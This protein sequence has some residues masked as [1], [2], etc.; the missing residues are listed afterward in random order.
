MTAIC[1]PVEN[2]KEGHRTD[3]GVQ[4]LNLAATFEPP[5]EQGSRGR[6]IKRLPLL[7]R[8]VIKGGIELTHCMSVAVCSVCGACVHRSI[9]RCDRI[10][11]DH[12]AGISRTR[13]M[14][15]LCR[16]GFSSLCEIYK[17]AYA[18]S[19]TLPLWESA[20]LIRFAY[21]TVRYFN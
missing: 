3:S 18:W 21:N 16:D 20:S 12:S 14:I 15:Q 17:E 1:W 13:M 4:V 19:V 7:P 5:I 6:V 8:I 2:R 9:A 11:Y 10:Y